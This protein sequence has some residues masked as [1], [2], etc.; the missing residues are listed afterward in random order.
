MQTTRMFQLPSA[1]H[2][3]ELDALSLLRCGWL[4]RYTTLASG[5]T[6]AMWVNEKDD[7]EVRANHGKSKDPPEEW[8]RSKAEQTA[9]ES[10]NFCT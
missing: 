8:S 6:A 10:P 2:S 1:V 3:S 7:M 5:E 4:Y 9:V